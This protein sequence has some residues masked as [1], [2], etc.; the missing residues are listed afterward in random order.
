MK[1]HLPNLV[2]SLNLLTGCISIALAF[3]DVELASYLVMAAMILD[4]LDGALAR[5]LD[6]RSEF[7]KQLDSLA[8]LVSFGMAPAMILYIVFLKSWNL[9]GIS[10]SYIYIIPLTAFLIPVFSALR[11]AR[12]NLDNS[13]KDIFRGLPTPANA[14]LIISIPLIIRQY[15]ESSQ[16]THFL[17]DTYT[18]IALILLSCFLLVSG[19]HLFSLKFQN[20]RWG[21]N[22]IRHI[23]LL[24]AVVLFAVLRFASIPLIIALYII[25]SLI[26]V[27]REGNA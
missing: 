15:G 12:F 27:K 2:S 19:V 18:L 13:G 3:Y 9:P 20:F 22:K 17:L 26:F 4:F 5:W 6:A 14:L 8:D 16:I 21:E 24:T 7:G 23:F 1:K 11:L 10:I 25:L